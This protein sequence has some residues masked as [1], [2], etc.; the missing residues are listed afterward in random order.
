MYSLKFLFTRLGRT[1]KT[2]GSSHRRCSLR[3]VVL[4]NLG[5]FIGK[6][7]CRSLFLITLQGSSHQRCSINKGILRNFATFP[8]K[9]LRQT[10]S[11]DC[12]W[13]QA[14]R[15]F[16]TGVFLLIL[17]N[18]C[19]HLL[20]QLTALHF[21]ISVLSLSDAVIWKVFLENSCSWISKVFSRLSVYNF[22]FTRK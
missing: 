4:K 8:G 20:R 15:Y 11:N 7:L 12:F 16:D 14:F 3:K 9:H 19:E 13:L 18:F 21:L 2:V 10:F 5:N 6:Q 17:L 1:H 22:N